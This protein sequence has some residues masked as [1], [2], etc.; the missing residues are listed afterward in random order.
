MDFA[1]GFWMTLVFLRVKIVNDG[2]LAWWYEYCFFSSW[3]CLLS[4]GLSYV[5][6]IKHGLGNCIVFNQLDDF[7]NEDIQLFLK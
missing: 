4:Y 1:K 3:Y 6:G 7:Y 2:F 5:L